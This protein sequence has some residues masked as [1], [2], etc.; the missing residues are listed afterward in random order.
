MRIYRMKTCISIYHG[1]SGE[2]REA[3][4]HTIE[5]VAYIERRGENF[6]RFSEVEAVLNGYMSRYCNQFLNAFPEFHGD[7][8]IEGIGETFFT[9]ISATLERKNLALKRLEV[10]ETPLRRYVVGVE[11]PVA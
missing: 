8:S 3:H 4:C 6:V 10:S 2:R 1:S 9:G 5:V 11:E 7:T